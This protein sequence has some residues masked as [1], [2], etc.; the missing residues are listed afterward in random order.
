MMKSLIRSVSVGLLFL[1]LGMGTLNAQ[2][3]TFTAGPAI[4]PA[5]FTG[6]QG[7]AWGDL[8][9]SG[10]LDAFVPSNN[11]LFNAFGTFTPLAASGIP[12]NTNVLGCLIAD[13]TG[14]GLPDILATV[15]STT[16]PKL[17]QNMAKV[18]FS[19]ITSTQGD[20][21][22]VTSGA[23][24]NIWGIAAADYNRDGYLDILWAGATGTPPGKLRL[25]KGSTTG[26]V[27]VGTTSAA[28]VI[29][30]NK[31]FESW[32]PVFVDANGDGY[33]DIFLPSMRNG[34]PASRSILYLNDK[35]GNFVLPTGHHDHLG[36]TTADT[37]IVVNDTVRYYSA[38]A[39][40]YGDFN[41]DG[42]VD[43][44]LSALA[45]DGTGLRLLYGNGD[46]TFMED[47]QD[48]SIHF[49][50]STRAINVGDYNN[51]GY[52]DILTGGSG[53]T[54][55]KL[56]RN[57]GDGTFTDETADLP[58]Q[59]AAMRAIGFVDFSNN[60]RMDIFGS[61][62]SATL[63]LQNGGNSNHWI[64][65]K[66]IGKGH[67]MSAVGARFTVYTNGGTMKQ[68]RDIS[69][70]GG[71]QG[72][73]GSLWANF[74]IGTATSVDSVTVQWP[75]GP[76][77]SYVLHGGIDRYYTFKEGAVVPA[78]PVLVTPLNGATNQPPS[79]TMTWNKSVGALG[80]QVQ[81]SLDSTFLVS[82]NIVLNDSTITSDTTQ[83][84]TGLG[85]S[86]TYYWR[87][88]A[89]GDGFTSGFSAPFHY[90]T[91]VHA[92]V[93]VP[94]LLSPAD[95]SVNQPA[96]MKLICSKTTDAAQYHWQVSTDGS[97]ATFAV[98]DSTTDTTRTV[99][100]TS[101]TKYYW[102]VQGV[103]PGG[104]ASFQT[105]FS[106]TVKTAPV[107]P[108]LSY[109]LVNQMS[110]RADTLVIKWKSVPSADK[111]ICQLSLN[112]A[113][114][115][116][117]VTRD[118]SSDTTF[119]V[120]GLTNLTKY[121]WRVLAF[122]IG[123]SSAF[124]AVDSFTTIV[125]KPVA[126]SLV[127]PASNAS[128]IDRLPTLVWRSSV[129][130]TKYHVQVATDN[131]FATIVANVTVADTS[132]NL[133]TLLAAT[134]LHYWHVS[135][136]DTLGEGVFSSLRFFTTGLI[137]G[138]DK[139]IELPKEYALRQNYPN[140]FNPSTIISYDLPKNSHVTIIIYDI[141]G[142]VVASLVNKDQS[143]SRYNVEWSPSNLSSGVYLYRIEARSDDKSGNFVSVKKLLFMK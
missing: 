78:L 138:I 74:G 61:Y 101:A 129:Y 84:I 53:G 33:Q 65:F 104:V 10:T 42:K 49:D 9:S 142:R 32:N 133:S 85:P 120:V 20:L 91:V 39:S 121:Y 126:P 76:K 139:T 35:N 137:T 47:P 109:P 23:S 90:T 59:T 46:G 2:E 136:I 58:A 14:D 13:F 105:A 80:Y 82:A 118:T 125:P 97:F 24:S 6:N 45:A 81:V 67:N 15:G 86:T 30:T 50:G 54:Q 115:S 36:G 140:P 1:V 110:V 100:L 117:V 79:L 66:P 60:G 44:L 130:A 31:Q 18:S 119:T 89:L 55:T 122:N 114:S 94:T 41:N 51:D 19:D 99:T 83:I 3:V 57:N 87:L 38:I 134:T 4:A 102:R 25:L 107:I 127:S 112:P 7:F 77:Q 123:G 92:P 62:G 88:R 108:V 72:M 71:A 16:G 128:D 141:L 22:T 28:P 98:N 37:G 132:V 68:I 12:T 135:A 5:T 113:F 11:I 43:L 17:Y 34:F 103:N 124:A 27:N 75:D 40:S 96:I 26:F 111:Y 93:L 69:S 143:A 106:F 131:A 56:W 52:L 21:A 48:T 64:A 95:N 63:S 8:D 29:D 73:G 70:N 116:L